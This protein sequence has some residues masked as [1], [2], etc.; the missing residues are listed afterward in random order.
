[1]LD[2]PKCRA[3]KIRIPIGPGPCK[4][5]AS[6]DDLATVS[7][8]PSVQFTSDKGCQFHFVITNG[9]VQDA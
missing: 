4:W 3:H 7:I 1:M 2:C 6:T 8:F 5:R 9:E